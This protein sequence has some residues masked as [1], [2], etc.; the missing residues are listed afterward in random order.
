MIEKSQYIHCAVSDVFK[1]FK[2]FCNQRHR[3]QPKSSFK[4]Q[5]PAVKDRPPPFG[6]NQN[7]SSPTFSLPLF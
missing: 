6:G 4:N 3:N 5:P 7:R 1:L 2:S